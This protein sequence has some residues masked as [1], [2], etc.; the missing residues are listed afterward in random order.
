[1][2]QD[3][4]AELTVPFRTAVSGGNAEIVIRRPTG[5]SEA[6]DVKIPAGIE[7]GQKIRLRG[8]G[9]PGGAGVG[10]LIITVHVAPHPHFRRSG[11]D[12]EVRVPVTLGEASL[13]AKIDVPSPRG[14]IRVTVP[15]GT[16][17]GT[18]LRIKGQGVAS[19]GRSAG[20]LYAEIVLVLPEGLDK[21]DRRLLEEISKKHPQDPRSLLKW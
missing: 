6:I 17:G 10:D 21:E 18:R 19:A 16:S 2:G 15:P 8:Q 11:R 20:D 14:T 3:I 4:H 1:V 7:D 5:K 12:L 13:G 9:G